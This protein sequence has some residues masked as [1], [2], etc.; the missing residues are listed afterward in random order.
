MQLRLITRLTV[1][2]LKFAVIAWMRLIDPATSVAFAE[3][4]TA[5]ETPLNMHYWRGF[6][7]Y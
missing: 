6:S 5:H 1:M 7:Y 2:R 3:R 4:I